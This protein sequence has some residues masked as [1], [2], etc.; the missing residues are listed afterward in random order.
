[1][2]DRLLEFAR[3]L[4]EA[5]GCLAEAE[6]GGS[7]E[8]VLA[9]GVSAALGLP[10]MCRLGATSAGP[11]EGVLPLSVASETFERLGRLVEESGR[12]VQGWTGPLYLKKEGLARQA[13][14]RFAGGNAAVRVGDPLEGTV[15]WLRGTYRWTAIS[16]EKREGIVDLVLDERTGLES[17]GM[18]ERWET[19]PRSGG[20]PLSCERLPAERLLAILRRAVER[21]VREEIRPF[22]ASLKRRLERDVRRAREYYDDIAWEIRR[23]SRRRSLAGEDLAKEEER[24]R[25]T[26]AELERKLSSLAARYG[27]KVRLSPIALER[28]VAP[29]TLVPMTILRKQKER[30][31]F[32]VWN[33]LLKELEPLACDSCGE[34]IWGFAACTEAVHLLCGKCFSR[35]PRCERT[36]CRACRGSGCTCGDRTEREK[37]D[38]TQPPMP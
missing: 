2:N 20:A 5:H 4:F 35:C 1:V 6:P 9:P 8:V 13:A 15:S 38:L 30:K 36:V 16:E 7:L 11:A 12:S 34:A 29:C 3:G 33:A 18:L 32:A 26:E 24:I 14:E 23:R 37:A 25:A 27:V 17:G 21:K 10:E 22:A 31:L 28:I 19:L